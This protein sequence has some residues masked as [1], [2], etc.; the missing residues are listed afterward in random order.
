MSVESTSCGVVGKG[1]IARHKQFLLL[2][3]PF[4]CD[5]V[6]RAIADVETRQFGTH[7]NELS[8]LKTCGRD[9]DRFTLGNNVVL[10]HKHN[11]ARSTD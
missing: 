2:A 8:T 1:E 3:Q 7:I 11:S 6:A 10:D 4:F 5:N 9:W